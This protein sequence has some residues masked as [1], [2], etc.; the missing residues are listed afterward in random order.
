MKRGNDSGYS[1]VE[2]LAALVI[3]GSMFALLISGLGMSRKIWDNMDRR[4][5]STD[6]VVGAQ[7]LLRD[8]LEK[9]FPQTKFDSTAPYSDFKGEANDLV[10]LAPATAAGGRQA[11]RRY[12]LKLQPNGDLVLFSASD[13]A[14]PGTPL[15]T[16]VLLH[17]V[18]AM[19][20]AYYGPMIAAGKGWNPRWA[21]RAS[22]P[23]LVRVHLEF[24]EGDARFWPD[25]IVRPA[26]TVDSLCVLNPATGHCR[27][28]A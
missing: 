14:R 24:A 17:Q 5:N 10:F 16:Q 6:I 19:A 27:G 15:E 28:R 1:L 25:L 11:L 8:R 13:L 3:L 9:A 20:F 21:N 23:E 7:M 22:L 18:N 26:A 12:E 2:A 4:G